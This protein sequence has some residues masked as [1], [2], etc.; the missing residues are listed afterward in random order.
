MRLRLGL[1]R[2]AGPACATLRCR[3]GTSC[4][5]LRPVF[6]GCGCHTIQEGRFVL[7]GLEGHLRDLRGLRG[8]FFGVQN[9][10]RLAD[11]LYGRDSDPVEAQDRVQVRKNLV[12]ASGAIDA[13][14]GQD[15]E[16]GYPAL[17]SRTAVLRPGC[18][19]RGR[20][21]GDR[22]GNACSRCDR[23]RCSRGGTAAARSGR[24]TRDIASGDSCRCRGLQR[25]RLLR[26]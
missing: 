8:A 18:I 15:R 10:A 22:P 2:C 11:L 19:H 5:R 17:Q 3:V 12:A 1:R 6:V 9:I 25:A 4:R 24:R 14:S 26:I 21:L 7:C 23:S 16:L 13:R 20:H